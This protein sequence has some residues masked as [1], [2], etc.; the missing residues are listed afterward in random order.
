M[1]LTKRQ[2]KEYQAK[3]EKY[4]KEVEELLDRVFYLT[5]DMPYQGDTCETS[6]RVC[7]LNAIGKV[8]SNVNGLEVSDFFEDEDSLSYRKDHPKH[9]PD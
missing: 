5:E 7:L 8:Q 1:K 9:Y 3:Y 4:K 6:Q 2:L